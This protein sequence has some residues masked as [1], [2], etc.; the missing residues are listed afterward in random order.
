[1]STPKVSVVVPCYN[2]EKYLNQCIDSIVNQTLRD[3]EIICVN[4]GSK[5]STLDILKSYAKNDKR[6]KIIDKPNGG[7]GE[8][9]NRGFDMA[10]GEYI[11]IIESDDFAELDMFEK[12]Y[13]C[14]KEHSLDAVKSGFYFYWSK[15]GERNVP[16]PIASRITSKKT[17][18]PSTDFKSTMEMVE[19]FNYKPSIWS[20]IYRTDFIRENGIRFNETPGASFQDTAFNFKVWSLA[21]RARLME[22]CFLH[23]RQDNEAS[24]INNPGKVYCICDEYAEIDRFLAAHPLIKA[25]VE[26][27]M[28]RVKFDGYFWNYDRLSEPLQ[29]EFIERFS[30]E[31]A[32]HMADGSLRKEYFEWYKWKRVHQIIEK[33]KKFHELFVKVKNGEITEDEAEALI[34]RRDAYTLGGKEVSPFMDKLLGGYQCIKDHGVIY[35]IKLGFKKLSKGA[36]K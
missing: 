24:S 10:T 30:E 34:W 21:E 31:F 6:V 28:V 8:S 35:T 11:G 14:A 17:F 1:M 33:P 16:H 20:A 32:R 23:Y 7:Y 12:L 27:V 18:C 13:N 19:F 4:D 3:I 26:P 2:V 25:A 5:D 15:D 36:K 29:A 9:M 22:E